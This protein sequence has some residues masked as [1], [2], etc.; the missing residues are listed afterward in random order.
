LAFFNKF[1]LSGSKIVANKSNI[2][3]DIL[4][5]YISK[6]LD[7][8]RR[9]GRHVF[10]DLPNFVNTYAYAID[11]SL[12][13][14]SDRLADYCQHT[15]LHGVRIQD[16]NDYLQKRWLKTVAMARGLTGP[17]PLDPRTACLMEIKS[18]WLSEAQDN[19][20]ITFN[21]PTISAI[22]AYEGVFY[23]HVNEVHFYGSID[24]DDAEHKS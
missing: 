10:Y 5:F 11:Y 2:N 17:K 15:D 12:S 16:I 9:G 4:G 20:Y 13:M 7:F 22:C 18:T 23:F 1:T 24:F 8:L 6:Y 3:A 21:P 19:F 14:T